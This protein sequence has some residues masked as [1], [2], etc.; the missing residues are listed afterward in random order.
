MPSIPSVVELGIGQTT[1]ASGNDGG[2]L[3][4]TGVDPK[5]LGALLLGTWTD[6][7]AGSTVTVQNG[8]LYVVDTTGARSVFALSNPTDG[9]TFI[10]S[11]VGATNTNGQGF[12]PVAGDSVADLQN[13]GSFVANPGEAIDFDV[14]AVFGLKY[15]LAHRRWVRVT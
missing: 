4:L 8:A 2:L 6:V 10:C 14:G 1:L 5:S 9:F 7:A 12:A 11:F 13:P 3:T 15:Q